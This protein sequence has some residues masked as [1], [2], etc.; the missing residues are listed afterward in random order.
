MIPAQR[1]AESAAAGAVGEEI[2]GEG[3]ATGRAE[4]RSRT[5]ASARSASRS[6]P[7]SP[8]SPSPPCFSSPVGRASC[9]NCRRRRRGR[10]CRRARRARASLANLLV[11]ARNTRRSPR[12][13]SSYGTSL[14]GSPAY[15]VVMMDFFLAD[16][17]VPHAPLRDVTSTASFSRWVP[18]PTCGEARAPDRAGALV[19]SPRAVRAGFETTARACTG[20]PGNTSPAWQPSPGTRPWYGESSYEAEEAW[21]YRVGGAVDVSGAWRNLRD[22]PRV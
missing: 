15:R 8:R 4:R 10:L 17:A 11:R 7:R 3:S 5:F 2:I 22:A 9:A 14:A 18:V 16:Q 1:A 6:S 12:G 13:D 19:P 20:T 21:R